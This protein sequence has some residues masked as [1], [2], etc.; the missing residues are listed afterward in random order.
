MM[1]LCGG[2]GGDGGIFCLKSNPKQSLPQIHINSVD[3]R[4]YYERRLQTVTGLSVTR[5]HCCRERRTLSTITMRRTL[6]ST[7]LIHSCEA[8]LGPKH[9]MRTQQHYCIAKQSNRLSYHHTI[10]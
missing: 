8:P 4:F 5:L 3:S 10:S 6:I 1:L 7:S 2:G 9:A